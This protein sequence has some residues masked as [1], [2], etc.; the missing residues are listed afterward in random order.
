IT[1]IKIELYRNDEFVMEIISSTFNDGEYY[2]GVP[3]G[4]ISSD[5]YQIKIID[6]LNASIFEYSNYFE[7]KSP[8]SWL[9]IITPDNYSSWEHDTSRRIS[10]F[11]IG[12]ISDIKIELYRNDV[13]VM[14]IIS[15]TF[16]DG[17]YYWVVSSGLI[18]S[19]QYQIKIIDILNA[20][21]FDYSDYF[22]IKSPSSTESILGYNLYVLL[23]ILSIVIIIIGRSRKN[24]RS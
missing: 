2:W 7:I 15:S 16:N 22:E 5:Q 23:T 10:W 14:E 6:I 21:V 13:F 19:D 4:L 18:S 8:S 1:G 11:S 20:S 12:N 3:L 9:M 17:E 24:L